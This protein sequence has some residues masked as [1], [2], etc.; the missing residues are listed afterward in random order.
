M[1][2][3][4]NILGYSVPSVGNVGRG[5]LLGGA[6]RKTHRFD[7][8]PI[9]ALA[10]DPRDSLSLQWTCCELCR[11]S[12]GVTARYRA[13]HGYM[14]PRLDCLQYASRLRGIPIRVERYA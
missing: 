2:Q 6:R 8:A 7:A 13:D 12:Y 1:R 14:C 11:R 4:V 10:F 3:I 9:V 5:Y